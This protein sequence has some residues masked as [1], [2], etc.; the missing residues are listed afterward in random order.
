MGIL[1]IEGD[2]SVKNGNLFKKFTILSISVLVILISF[3]PSML[4]FYREKEKIY[5]PKIAIKC[6]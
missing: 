3:F 2:N 4:L 6:I 5:G 1:S